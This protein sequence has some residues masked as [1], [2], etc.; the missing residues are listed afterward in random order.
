LIT[1]PFTLLVT[2]PVAPGLNVGILRVMFA[3]VLA[4][5]TLGDPVN[6]PPMKNGGG[7]SCI[8]TLA[9]AVLPLAPV[10]VRV[11]VVAVKEAKG[12]VVIGVP[13]VTGS[14]VASW[15]FV[16]MPLPPEKTAVSTSVLARVRM[17]AAGVKL[18]MLGAG[19][20]VICAVSVAVLP[21]GLVTTSLY[22]VVVFGETETITPLV[23]GSVELS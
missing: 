10:T 3:L 17:R 11:N 15:S 13:L 18:L 12:V 22:T 16:I 9:V 2:T 8:V 4:V 1:V 20:T 14:V 7:T 5:T 6:D 19:T 21:A 23:T